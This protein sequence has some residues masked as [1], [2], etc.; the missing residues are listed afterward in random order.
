[1]RL[2]RL[3]LQAGLAITSIFLS[4]YLWNHPLPQVQ[5]W[6]LNIIDLMLAGTALA[7]PVRRNE[8]SHAVRGRLEDRSNDFGKRAA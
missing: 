4:I 7:I 2:N 5:F 3:F 6:T 8:T 1:M